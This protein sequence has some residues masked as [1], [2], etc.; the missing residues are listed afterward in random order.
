[1]RNV[2]RLMHP[3]SSMHVYG[4]HGV[5]DAFLLEAGARPPCR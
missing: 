2:F 4:S 5:I 3:D 1:M